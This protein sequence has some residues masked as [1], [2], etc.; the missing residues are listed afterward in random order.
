MGAYCSEFPL[1]LDGR[2]DTAKQEIVPLLGEGI[3]REISEET[4]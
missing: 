1:T 3:F 2:K 4:E